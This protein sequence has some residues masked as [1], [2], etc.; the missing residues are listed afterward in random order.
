[1]VES[2]EDCSDCVRGGWDFLKW[3]KITKKIKGQEL[4]GNFFA[5][6]PF[7]CCPFGMIILPKLLR[8]GVQARSYSQKWVGKTLI[9]FT[10][11]PIRCANIHLF[12]L[13]Y[14][15]PECRSV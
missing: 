5:L 7:F 14:A 2:V 13:D 12:A 8:L 4:F 10:S 3:L 6:S 9:F 11:T 1:M 15:T